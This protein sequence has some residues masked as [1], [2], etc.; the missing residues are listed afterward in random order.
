MNRVF[1]ATI[2]FTLVAVLSFCCW[3]FGGRFFGS[4]YSLYAG[5][6]IVFFGLGGAALFPASG[7]GKKSLFRFSLAFAA[8]FLL[9]ALV[10]SVCWFG[11]KNTFGEILGSA[12]GLCLMIA[13]FRKLSGL[14]RGQS[15]LTATAVAFL[16]HSIGYY[17]GDFLHAAFLGRGPMPLNEIIGDRKTAAIVSKLAW[18]VCYGL[19]F[20]LGLSLV[21]HRSAQSSAK[22]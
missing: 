16:C 2:L 3:A 15:L 17:L 22:P 10:W 7:L 14:S 9:Y 8:S 5:C 11:L 20:G 12:L 6:A 13:L 4:E 19:G 18:G 21:L 1:L